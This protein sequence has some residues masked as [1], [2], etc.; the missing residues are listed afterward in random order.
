MCGIA[1]LVAKTSQGRSMKKELEEMLDIMQHRGP[2]GRESVYLP[3]VDIGMVRLAIVDLE[4]GAQPLWNE[5]H[6]MA[7]VCNGEIYNST[8][9]RSRL[10]ADGHQFKTHSDVEVVLHLYEEMGE[11]CL[12]QLEGIYALAIWNEERK[13]L[14]VARDRMGVKP[15]YYADIG[16]HWA[17]A[18]ELRALAAL[19]GVAKEIEDSALMAYHALRFTPREQTLYRSI[20]RILPAHYAQVNAGIFRIAPYWKP[21][22]SPIGFPESSG[23]ED[24][25]PKRLREVMFAAVQSQFAP[26]VN[27]AVLLSGGL[28]S[29]A[30]LAMRRELSGGKPD[31]AITVAFER[32]VSGASRVEYSEVEHAA[33]VARTYQA[34]HIVGVVNARDALEA[35]PQIIADLDEPIADPTAIPL[36]FATRIAHANDCKVVY[37]GEGLDELF[38]GYQVY[39]HERWMRALNRVPETLR[40]SLLEW[41]VRKGMPGAGVIGRSLQDI[42]DWYQGV[43][44]IFTPEERSVLLQTTIS[45]GDPIFA[46]AGSQMESSDSLS[47]LQRMM[48]FDLLTWLPDNTLAKSDKISMAHSVELRVPYLDSRIVDFALA[49]PDHKTWSRGGKRIV[50]QALTGVVPSFVVRRRKAG[51]NVPI[52]A[53]LFGEWQEF[54]REMLLSPHAATRDLYGNRIHALF[55]AP[56]DR[57]ERAGRLLFALLTLELWLRQT[58]LRTQWEPTY[59]IS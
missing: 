11:R 59:L 39:G 46:H 43:G 30:L 14:F 3:G 51:F 28:D 13:T 17:F 5:D 26:E 21:T 38:A 54:A 2:D 6:T 40:R 27:S 33:R 32:P 16:S 31:I 24:F 9:L 22:F 10:I 58:P 12:N 52:S 53:W 19:D 23:T 50:R 15:L 7:L 45:K 34:E 56:R 44:G 42:H 49:C 4:S 47:A 29:T 1:L 41:L 25:S 55:E 36:W 35:L 48:L 18:S 20:R 8:T 37:S 57:Q